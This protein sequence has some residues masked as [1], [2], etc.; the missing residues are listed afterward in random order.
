MAP[1]CKKIDDSYRNSDTPTRTLTDEAFAKM[2]AEMF[3]D[4]KTFIEGVGVVVVI[5][6]VCVAANA[7]AMSMRERVTEVAVLKA[8]GFNKGLVTG[9]VLAEAMFV[10]G[11]GGLVGTLGAK[12]LFDSVDISRYSAGFLPFFYV[13][14]MT[15]LW[16]QL[17]AVTIG[18]A[19]GIIPAIRAATL[20][21]IDGLR[22]VV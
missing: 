12:L 7:M 9:L 14:W 5:S 10:A 16:G 6:L 20:S 19:S 21:V 8:I 22:K 15:A 1:L 4:M 18:L 11:V 3:G 17:A 13:P 2:F